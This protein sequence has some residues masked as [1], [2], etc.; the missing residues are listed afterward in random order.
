[1]PESM[2]LL[3]IEE[4]ENLKNFN[5]SIQRIHYVKDCIKMSEMWYSPVC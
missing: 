5:N 2:L 4:Y 1:M 3:C